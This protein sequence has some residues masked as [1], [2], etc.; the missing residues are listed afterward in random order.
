[1]S[2]DLN[3]LN[4]WIGT[5]EGKAWADGLKAPLLAKNKELLEGLHLSNGKTAEASRAKADLEKLYAEERGAVEKT[6]VDGEL[7]RLLK[8]AGAFGP[9]IP[10]LIAELKQAYGLTVAANGAERKAIG[11]MKTTGP[12]GVEIEKDVGLE[13]IVKA[14]TMKPSSKDLILDRGGFGGGAPGSGSGHSSPAPSLSGLSGPEL[15]RMS[16]KDFQAAIN[17]AR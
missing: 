5:D 11:K 8:D 7:A 3:E 15:A 17:E 14:W 6:V 13:E 9:V 16:D 10:G 12:D 1:M 4:T 2:I